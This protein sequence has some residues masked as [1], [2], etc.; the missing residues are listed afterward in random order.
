MANEERIA[1]LR[2]MIKARLAAA[3]S[4]ADRYA[5]STLSFYLDDMRSLDKE[6]IELQDQ[7]E[8]LQRGT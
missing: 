7:I 6:C 3:A 8:K 1:L 2:D 4:A 5:K